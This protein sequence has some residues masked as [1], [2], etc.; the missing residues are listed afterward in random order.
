MKR[1]PCC[2]IALLLPCVVGTVVQEKP[3]TKHIDIPM[4]IGACGYAA[5]IQKRM[6]QGFI[7]ELIEGLT[8]SNIK[9]IFTKIIE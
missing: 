6:S 2:D 5:F 3:I 7:E 1:R 9:R 8:Y 4:F